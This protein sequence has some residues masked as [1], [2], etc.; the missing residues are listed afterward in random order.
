MAGQ[1]TRRKFV[2][3][4][5]WATVSCALG[6]LAA[7]LILQWSDV[8][9]GRHTDTSF[10]LFEYDR[11]LGWRMRPHLDTTYDFVDTEGIPIR[12]NSLGFPDEEFELESNARCRVALLGDSFTQGA[13]IR[14]EER[15]GEVVAAMVP[16]VEVLNFG[17]PAYGDDQSL[18]VWETVARRYRPDVVV[19]TLYTNDY[20]ENMSSVV[21]GRRKPYFELGAEG[22]LQLRGTPVDP[23]LFWDDGVFHQIAPCYAGLHDRPEVRRSRILHWLVKNSELTRALY[24]GYRAFRQPVE[25]PEAPVPERS[26]PEVPLDAL[27][28]NQVSLAERIVERLAESVHASGATFIVMIAGRMEPRFAHQMRR[29]E[30]AGLSY[31]DATDATL[32]PW[33]LQNGGGRVFFRFNQH[34]TPEAHR[35]AAELLLRRLHSEPQCRPDPPPSAPLAA[36]PPRSP[37]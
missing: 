7:E 21:Y 33:I 18:L 2:F 15:F 9:I 1:G 13:G 37:A 6:A 12:S 26:R 35:A 30:T 16:G 17:I 27:R 28:E 19:L 31:V 29:L 11:L 23:K 24:T 4:V 3:T 5:I 14:E 34:W 32:Q 20:E 22:G 8:P 25:E 10:L 36:A